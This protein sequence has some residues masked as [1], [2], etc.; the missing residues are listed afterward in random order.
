MHRHRRSEQGLAVVE[1]TIM[2]PLLLMMVFGGFEIY[3]LLLA[4]NIIIGMSR[5]GANL[6]ARTTEP[7]QKV[8]EVLSTTA[9]PLVMKDHGT[10]FV[11][12][13]VGTA[14]GKPPRVQE[15][16][17]WTG[18]SY[19]EKSESR[20]WSGCGSA[21]ADSSYWDNGSCK[22]PDTRPTLASFDMEMTEGETIHVV[23]V[24]Y[25]YENIIAYAI[26]DDLE[27]YSRSLL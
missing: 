16:Y 20:V 5:E 24:M 15:Q 1:M 18:S 12:V 8:M 11:T 17:R 27:L 23:E 25:Q 21:D 7:E 9:T 4:N 10:M 22:L 26:T 19:S 3:R 2:L 14:D 6:V 13:L